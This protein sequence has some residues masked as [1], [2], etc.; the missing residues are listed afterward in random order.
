MNTRAATARILLEVLAHGRALDTALANVC[1]QEWSD[2][3][4]RFIQ[5]L[6]FGTLRWYPQL[7]GISL[8]LLHKPLA[9]KHQV[10]ECLLLIGLYQLLHLQT[11]AYAAIASTVDAVKKLSKQSW[12]PGLVNKI[13]RM[14]ASEAESL[15]QQSLQHPTWQYAHP[16]WLIT[17]IQQQWP[18]H[19]SQILNANNQPAPLT[20]RVNPRRVSRESYQQ[21]LA[22]RGIDAHPISGLSDALQLSTRVA[23][24]DLPGFAEGDCYIQDAAGQFAAP[25]LNLAP[26]QHVLDA[27]AAPGSKTTAILTQ[28]PQ[29]ASL[30]AVDISAERLAKIQ[31]NVARLQLDACALTLRCGDAHKLRQDYPQGH[32]D[33]IL[34]DAPCSATGVI[35][36]HPDIKVLRQPEDIHKLVKEQRQLLQSLWTLLAP[37]GTLLYATCSVLR[38][39][40]DDVM[41]NF[42]EH[43]P[44]AQLQTIRVPGAITTT[45]GCQLL[46]KPNGCDGFYYALI[47]KVA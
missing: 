4:R 31:E 24:A 27:C 41:A 19:W 39:E 37:G 18:E 1:W 6:C 23:V 12:A 40:N 11:P 8:S 45:H 20:L 25:L 47:H 33:R 3:D 14:A 5:E 32:F 17:R 15:V 10:I 21:A 13:L 2:A 34:L 26:G 30:V 7:Q 16:A 36:R 9:R 42:L 35:R 28:E 44:D 46:P 29:L 43:T 38:D 22:A